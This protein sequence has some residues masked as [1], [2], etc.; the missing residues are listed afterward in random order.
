MTG[1]SSTERILD[2]FLA[3]EADRLPDRVIDAALADIARTPQ[4]RALRVPWR[5]PLMPALTRATSLG[6]VALVAA[7]AVGGVMYIN[8]TGPGGPGGQ[9]T[10]PATA[11]PNTTAP[12]SEPTA[13]ASPEA[14]FVA[15]GI[16]GWKTYRSTVY[17]YTISYPDDWLVGARATQKWQPG[18]PEGAPSV[19]LFAYDEGD[20]GD[21]IAFFAIQFPAPGGANL[22]SWEGLLAA[23][24]EMCAKPAEF[25]A[26]PCPSDTVVVTRMCRGT[27][28]QPVAFAREDDFPSAIFGDPD[29]G[30]VTYLQMGRR[31]DYPGAAR[32]GGS[33]MLLKSILGEMGVRE[34]GPGDTLN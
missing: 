23:L 10:P 29:T 34:A 24:T 32:Y 21:S 3:P 26:S 1:R 18:D 16:T 33:E 22:G 8:S 25:Y 17:D 31:D 6:A 20:E 12:T 9:T 14:S 11:T 19:D 13:L 28:C 2:A 7:V 4:R 5:F 15:P 30:I 27:D